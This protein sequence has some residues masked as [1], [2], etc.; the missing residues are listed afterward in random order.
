LVVVLVVQLGPITYQGKIELLVAQVVV[1]PALSLP[2][3]V[4]LERLVREVLEEVELPVEE[5]VVEQVALEK[6]VRTL[7]VEMVVL[8]QM[9]LLILVLRKQMLF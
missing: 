4:Q 3:A 9:I 1:A 7:T 2:L 8:G 6:T 5:V